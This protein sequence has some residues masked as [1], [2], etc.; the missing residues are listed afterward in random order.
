MDTQTQ[1]PSFTISLRG[2]DRDEVD[3]YLHSMSD[4]IEHLEDAHEQN[5]RLQGHINRL[6]ARIKD[7]EERIHADTPRTGAVLG[8]RIS[9][10]LESAENT[11]T[12]TIERADAR[13]AEI[14][15]EAQEQVAAAEEAARTAIEK[16][17]EQARRIEASARGEAAEIISEAEARTTA[18]TRQ[19]E[20]WAEEVVSHTR[21]EEARM[22][23]EHGEK[24]Q[25]AKAELMALSNRREATVSALAE[26][27]ETLGQA[28]TQV[29]GIA[30]VNEAEHVEQAEDAQE[31]EEAGEADPAPAEDVTGETAEPAAK[32]TEEPAREAVDDET[33]VPTPKTGPA[34]FYDVEA[35]DA[36]RTGEVDLSELQS[37]ADGGPGASP[38]LNSAQVNREEFDRKLEA[39][40]SEGEGKN[41]PNG[42]RHFRR[43]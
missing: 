28:L 31:A 14:V 42:A 17:E 34:G 32:D 30:I 26:L 39:W 4:S 13:A 12:D 19:I 41:L 40:V 11:A 20:Q 22:L 25:E 7:L 1:A 16:G 43:A 15:A 38:Q 37:G 18:R 8:E 33:R 2:Y 29:S 9:L 21:A 36:D 23:R 10:L 27:R 35:E 3:R 6:N 24:M 5:R